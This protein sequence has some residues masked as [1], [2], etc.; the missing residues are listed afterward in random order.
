MNVRRMLYTAALLVTV[1]SMLL[2][3]GGRAD[4]LHAGGEIQR[5]V[6]GFY[7]WYCA[8]YEKLGAIHLV[9]QGEKAS[10]LYRV[11]RTGV[12]EYIKQVMGSGFFTQSFPPK[13]WKYFDACEKQMLAAKQTEGPPAGLD[14]DLFFCGQ[15][16]S[17]TKEFVD[18]CTFSDLHIKGHRATVRVHTPTNGYTDI[19]LRRVRG[20]WKIAAVCEFR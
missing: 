8:H 4:S 18:N 13:I 6:R 5:V 1:S 11:D 15:D 16:Y 12:E 10:A 9:T 2:A 19:R 14:F 17:T 20:T 7:H 3:K